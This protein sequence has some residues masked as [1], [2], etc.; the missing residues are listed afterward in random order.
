MYAL[1]NG[2][3]SLSTLASRAVFSVNV[4]L[5]NLPRYPAT[6]ASSHAA[7]SISYLN[8]AQGSV[9]GV[10]VQS[11]SSTLHILGYLG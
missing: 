4:R 10:P 3:N 6:R 5:R 1:L 11:G 2:S 7:L 8:L 9:L